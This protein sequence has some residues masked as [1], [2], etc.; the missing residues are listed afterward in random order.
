MEILTRQ[1]ASEKRMHKY[2]TGKPCK[3]G[4]MALRYMNTGACT[5]CIAFYGSQR[6]NCARL[7]RFEISHPDDIKAVQDFVNSI[8]LARS[9]S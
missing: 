4:H 2:Y 5:D 9:L 1:Q 3:R 6:K 8:N 7:V